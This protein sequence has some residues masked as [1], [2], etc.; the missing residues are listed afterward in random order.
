MFKDHKLKEECGVFGIY[1]KND[2]DVASLSYFALYA[3]QHR[4]QQS[5]GIAVT[6][7]DGTYCYKDL[8]LVSEVFTEERLSKMSG[9]M[10][11]GHV[12]YAT[13]AE[14][15][16]EN[17]QPLCARYLKGSLCIAHNGSICNADKLR[18][19]LLQEGVIFQTSNDT[20]VIACLISR[21]RTRCGSVE[22]AVAKVATMLEGAFSM[23]VM[24]P[25]KLIAVRDRYGFRPLVMGK[26]KDSW[27]FA[28]ETCALEAIGAEFVRDVKPGEIVAITKDGVKENTD[29][30]GGKTA[31][32]IFEHIY[33][34]R[35]DSVLDGESVYEARINAGKILAE[36][37]PVDADMVIG[38]PDSGTVAAMGYAQG[39]G[40]PFGTGLIKNRYIGRTFIQP[41]Q[42]MREVSVSIKLNPLSSAVKG[43]RIVMIDDSIVRGT[44]IRKLIDLLKKAG[45]KEVHVR[46]SS[47]EFLWPCYFGT[48]IPDRSNLACVNYTVEE[49]REQIGADSL[50]FL[51]LDRV[52]EIASDHTKEDYCYACFSGEY[53]CE[54]PCNE[55]KDK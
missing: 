37:A 1:N 3:L 4:G 43:K 28:S 25:R 15:T 17:A 11:I 2:L 24:S 8:G 51:P 32:C 46:I 33:F 31:F 9:D 29:L 10:A 22:E 47:P 13:L 39:S 52:C 16:R 7:E 19:E 6:N 30:C 45:A 38:V 12:R 41:T 27:I 44:T 40:I 23:L 36:T 21:E 48:D 5:C 18:E 34:A 54:V 50:V 35:P 53:P 14:N 42:T 49:L 55:C 26:L 20:E